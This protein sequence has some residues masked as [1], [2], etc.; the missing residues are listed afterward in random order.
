MHFL[1]TDPSASPAAVSWGQQ[2]EK[3]R[4][5]KLLVWPAVPHG[6]L[7]KGSDPI[8]VEKIVIKILPSLGTLW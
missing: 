3:G 7:L 5:A 6:G 8:L 1:G 4:V 2:V